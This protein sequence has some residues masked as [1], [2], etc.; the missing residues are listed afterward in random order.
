MADQQKTRGTTGPGVAGGDGSDGASTPFLADAD[1]DAELRDLTADQ[2]RRWARL[3]ADGVEPFPQGLGAGQERAM[4]DE[5]RRFRRTRL[6]RFI[7]AQVARDV[8]A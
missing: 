8:L 2:A 3:V 4:L 1:T 7:A 5:V 6:V